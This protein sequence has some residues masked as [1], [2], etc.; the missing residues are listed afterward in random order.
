MDRIE[1]LHKAALQGDLA[2]LHRLV[3]E[4]PL[5]LNRIESTSAAAGNPLHT[6]SLRGD[7]DFAKELLKLRPEL[8]GMRDEGGSYPIHLAAAGG[9]VGVVRE[10]LGRTKSTSSRRVQD[11]DGR[12]ALHL[13]AAN[14]RV[15]VV[16]ELLRV[17]PE[18]AGVVSNRGETALHMCM[19]NNQVEAASEVLAGCKAELANV[20]DSE[21]NT[22]LHLATAKKQFKL[23]ELFLSKTQVDVKAT[24]GCDCTALDIL[25]QG[26]SD[27]GDLEISHL[28]SNAGCNRKRNT[29]QNSNATNARKKRWMPRGWGRRLKKDKKW[30]QEMHNTLLIVATLIATVTFAA[31]LSPPGGV[32]DEPKVL[33]ENRSPSPSPSKKS[34]CSMPKVINAGTAIQNDCHSENFKLFMYFDLSGL[35]SSL[36]I[37]LF[38][39]S[40]LPLKNC[41]TTWILVI[42][43]WVAVTS[44]IMAFIFGTVLIVDS[45]NKIVWPLLCI[46]IS[47]TSFM[48]LLLVW[49][50]MVLI[51]RLILSFFRLIFWIFRR[52]HI[53]KFWKSTDRVQV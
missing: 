14:G 36:F 44:V 5:L 17:D 39:V 49:H 26:P 8:A 18:L 50:L 41:L 37:I 4:D 1:S 34:D 28:L 24:N 10:I 21:G 43:M 12:T 19:R 47:W 53:P 11:K 16:G 15:E 23:L 30:Y 33:N 51:F 52:I 32:W 2:A 46:L 20:K 48:V 3:Q 25:S 27:Y 35:V 45:N 29:Q 38:L 22:V 31:G 13:A 40:R 6:A 42:T 7:V 9:H